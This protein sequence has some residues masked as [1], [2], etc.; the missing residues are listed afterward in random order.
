MKIRQIKTR[1]FQYS[2]EFE[3]LD[4]NPDIWDTM[5]KWCEETFGRPRKHTDLAYDNEPT[6]TRQFG[7]I[8]FKNEEQAIWFIMRFS[9]E[10]K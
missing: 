9:N 8:R 1:E 7:G 3:T 6:W 10:V 2:V 4:N 5:Y